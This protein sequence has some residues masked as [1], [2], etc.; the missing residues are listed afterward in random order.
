VQSLAEIENAFRATVPDD[1]LRG[2]INTRVLLRTGVNLR[3]IDPDKDRNPE[4]VE[5]VLRA[6]ADFGYRLEQG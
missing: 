5:Q 2:L 3:V 1:I 6:L 4:V